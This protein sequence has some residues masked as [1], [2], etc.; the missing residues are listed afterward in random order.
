M[1]KYIELIENEKATHLCI[2]LYYDLGGTSWATYQPKE[3]GYYLRVVPVKKETRYGVQWESFV[4]FTGYS[5]LIKPV[6]RKSAKAEAVAE[7]A[8]ADILDIMI[9]RVCQKNGL[10][11]KQ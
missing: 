5:Q 2:E 1:K 11:V 10:E 4:A 9:S 6:T 7:A 3:R 8:A